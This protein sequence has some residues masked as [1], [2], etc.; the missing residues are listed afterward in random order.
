MSNDNSLSRFF[1]LLEGFGECSGLK[2]N[3]DKSEI[4]LLGDCAHSSLNQSFFKSTKIKT[5]VKILGIHF[6]YD[7]RVKQ[8][9][10]FDEL[11][12]SIKDKLRIWR[13]RDLTIIGRI[14]IVKT[15]IIPI[16]LYRASMICLDEV[17]VNEVNKII[18]HFIWNGKD[19]IKRL[20]LINDIEDGGLKA[21]HVDSIIRTQRILCCKRL[22]SEQPSSWKTILLHYLK[23]VGGKCILCC[24]F[25]IKTLPIKLPTFL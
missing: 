2:I 9:L 14:Q 10:N 23:P 12:K 15:F 25:D 5:Y 8:K 3:H 6:T 1:E 24:D 22:A 11:I 21:P 13:W 18:F 7:Y 19:K 20:A 16:F 4:T 17:F